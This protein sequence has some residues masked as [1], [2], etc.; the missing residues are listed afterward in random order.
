MKLH[1]EGLILGYFSL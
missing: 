1:P